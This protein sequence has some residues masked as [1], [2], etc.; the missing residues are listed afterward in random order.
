[1]GRDES[2]ENQVIDI[3]LTEVGPNWIVGEMAG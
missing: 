2:V 1:L 3:H